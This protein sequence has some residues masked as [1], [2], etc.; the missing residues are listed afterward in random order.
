MFYEVLVPTFYDENADGVGDLAGVTS[1]LE[2]LKWLGVV[3]L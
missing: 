2:Y 3:C 1:K